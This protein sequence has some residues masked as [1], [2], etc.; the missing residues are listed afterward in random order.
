MYSRIAEPVRVFP[1][2]N[3]TPTDEDRQIIELTVERDRLLQMFNHYLAF[4]E[5][6]LV[7][8]ELLRIA[9]D[10][11]VLDIENNRTK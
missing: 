9:F 8:C 11:A 2:P 1:V 10:Y 3:Q 7:A 5:N 6:S 4:C